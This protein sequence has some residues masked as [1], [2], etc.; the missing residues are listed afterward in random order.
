L[1]A[2]DPRDAARLPLPR[3]RHSPAEQHNLVDAAEGLS[4]APEGIRIVIVGDH[5]VVRAG[6]RQVLEA[7]IYALSH[8]PRAVPPW[9]PGPDAR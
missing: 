5:P 6:L 3:D 4:V 7:V 1:R 2:S 8:Q 9:E